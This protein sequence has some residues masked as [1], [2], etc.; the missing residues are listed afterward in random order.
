[1]IVVHVVPLK[2]KSPNTELTK[3]DQYYH[4]KNPF[5]SKQCLRQITIFPPTN[6][7]HMVQ[8]IALLSPSLKKNKG[9]TSALCY[10]Y[11][12][13]YKFYSLKTKIFMDT[14]NH[15]KNVT[16]TAISDQQL[17]INTSLN[18]DKIFIELNHV[19]NCFLL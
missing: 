8:N 1:M 14:K 18:K 6:M 9:P 3:S 12:Q 19:A 11:S 10:K 5:S 15:K 16:L 4:Y 7:N 2:Q 17:K 13:L